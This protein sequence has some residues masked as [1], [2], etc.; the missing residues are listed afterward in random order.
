ML[1]KKILMTLALASFLAGGAAMAGDHEWVGARKCA[2]CHEKEAIGNQ[3]G[4]WAKTKHAKAMESLK[5][6]KAK[7]WAKEAGVADPLTDEKCVKCHTTAW[8]VSDEMKGSKFSYDE[9]V[10]CEACHGAGKDY[11]KKKVMVDHD[12]SV[13]KGLVE[14][15]EKTC[16]RC[17]NDKSPAWEGFDYKA[18]LK[19]IAHPV[20]EGYDPFAEDE[21]E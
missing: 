20:P 8:G 6:D 12:A 11:R 4:S 18:A 16:T 9:G 17:H 14:I 7:E 5:T 21:E 3:N 15:T 13:A 1:F 19:E 10:S 2:T